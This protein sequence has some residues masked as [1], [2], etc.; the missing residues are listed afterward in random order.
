MPKFIIIAL[1]FLAFYM[2]PFVSA[3]TL[4][5]RTFGMSDGLPNSTVKCFCQDDEGFIWMGTF[6]GLCRYDGI[7]FDVFQHEEGNTGSLS[8]NHVENILADGQLLW[9]GTWNGLECFDRTTGAFRLLEAEGDA[10]GSRILRLCKAGDKVWVLTTYGQVLALNEGALHLERDS[11][12]SAY[13]VKDIL[14]WECDALLVCTQDQL[15]SYH[16]QSGRIVPLADV[17][18]NAAASVRM[19]FDS[20]HGILCIGCALDYES[21]CYKLDDRG[22]LLKMD[23]ALP[24]D[25]KD[26]TLYDGC[27]IWATDG[28]GLFQQDPVTNVVEAMNSDALSTQAIHSLFVDDHATLWIGTYR[29]GGALYNPI[30]DSFQ[31]L[32]GDRSNMITTGICVQ[33]DSL[34]LGLDG[35]GLLIYNKKTGAFE[36]LD[37]SN[38]RLSGDNVFALHVQGTKAWLAIYERGIDCLD[39]QTHRRTHIPCD[40]G[41][42]SLSKIRD[43]GR[44]HLWFCGGHE[45]LILDTHD[46]SIEKA[47]IFGDGDVYDV[48]FADDVLWASCQGALLKLSRKDYR[49]LARYAHDGKADGALPTSTLRY[50]F[51]DN[52]GKLWAATEN[53]GLYKLDEKQKQFIQVPALG[54]QVV[55]N[56]VQDHEQTF[57][58]STLLGLYC[59]DDATRTAVRYREEDKLPCSQ[60]SYRAC[61]MSGDEIYLGTVQGPVWFRPTSLKRS[62]RN[63][64][65]YF[66]GLTVLGAKAFHQSW[67]K[68]APRQVEL[69]HDQNFFVVHFASPEFIAP[70]KVQFATLLEN[71]ENQWQTIG[72]SNEVRYTNVPPG[73][74]TLHLRASDALGNWSEQSAT[75]TIIVHAPW[76]QTWWARLL[77]CLLAALFLG[78]CLLI[79][80]HEM[81]MKHRLH[82]SRI[83][84]ESQRQLDEEKMK[85][86]VQVAHELRTPAFL[87]SASL[88]EMLS[89]QRKVLSVPHRKI[90][91]IYGNVQ[92]LN[93]LVSHVIDL[94]RDHNRFFTLNEVDTQ[95]RRFCL[96][97]ESY[98]RSLCD[99]K[100]IHFSLQQ[101]KADM[102]VRLDAEKL[103]TI[104]NNL[105]S[106]AFKYTSREGN[107]VLSVNIDS[108]ETHLCFS[109][110]DDGIGISEEQQ[111]HIFEE[112]YRASGHAGIQG[113]GVGLVAAKQLAELMHG[114]ISVESKEGKGSTFTLRLPVKRTA[115][116]ETPMAVL[117]SDTNIMPP[118]PASLCT[119]LVVDD[120]E[121][122]LHI[123]QRYLS[124]AY[125][126]LTAHD[127]NEGWTM[128]QEQMPDL[129]ITDMMMPGMDGGELLQLIKSNTRTSHIP[130]ILFTAKDTEED[131]FDAYQQGADAYITKP[132]SL[133][134][135]DLRIHNLLDQSIKVTEMLPHTNDKSGRRRYTREEK[136]FL[137]TCRQII[138][139][140]LSDAEFD[141]ENMSQEMAMSHSTLYRRIQK[142]TGLSV[143]DFINEYRLYRA[144]QM[145]RQGESNVAA[146]SERCGFTD[147]RTFSRAFK[148]KHGIS[149]KQYMQDI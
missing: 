66:T 5:L 138:E 40:V 124:T 79:Y 103:E 108:D 127:G 96:G 116:S 64:Q 36:T 102:T 140:H 145:M 77:W 48:L 78:G 123:V 112:Y 110:K 42:S 72:A 84:A 65:A 104:L 132:V 81:K 93:R 129:V 2:P 35:K 17:A 125:R 144:C 44:G 21:L 99:Q 91:K 121:E 88:E 142:V 94:R 4:R 1:T 51:L 37:A 60:F 6:N 62:H 34:I 50:I 16:P 26:V 95:L 68:E 45:V 12:L 111:Q 89:A 122:T 133:K 43:D 54:N 134:Y 20:E 86:F 52:A 119:I 109:V 29:G 55:V 76:W 148:A 143:K 139:Q 85:L 100:D 19:F 27:I 3:E 61:C 71:F 32:R 58:I 128:I 10:K 117:N 53:G 90:E 146:I 57:W 82:I 13:V 41:S 70:S 137:L 147:Y 101:P 73:T 14:P 98:Y 75:I 30:Y 33:G 69:K 83:Q 22:R 7:H 131:K 87:V 130:V 80:L 46:N 63:L 24:P 115:T 74:Y 114:T 107:I 141:V 97:L 92:R 15:F 118:S 135:L 31:T 25:A 59:Y 23:I 47:T 120:E 67:W 49:V 9:L 38:G 126:V 11:V 136:G 8:E 28:K 56:M 149:P 18:I 113:D 39:L 105:V 106:N